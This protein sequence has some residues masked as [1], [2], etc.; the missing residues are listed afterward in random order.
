MY[1]YCGYVGNP[2]LCKGYTVSLMF[3]IIVFNLL[4]LSCSSYGHRQYSVR[5][6]GANRREKFLTMYINFI[7]EKLQFVAGDR[8]KLNPRGE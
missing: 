4:L 1:F 8:R 7:K 5:P 6:A 2:V 3:I